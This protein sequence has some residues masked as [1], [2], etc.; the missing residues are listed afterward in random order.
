MNAPVSVSPDLS[1]ESSM[2]QAML[3]LLTSPLQVIGFMLP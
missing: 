2:S 3:L 1:V